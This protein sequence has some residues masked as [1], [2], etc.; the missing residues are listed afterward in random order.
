MS[1]DDLIFK[2]QNIN[3]NINLK[4]VENLGRR[5]SDKVYGAELKVKNDKIIPFYT[6]MDTYIKLQETIMKAK[7]CGYEDE[8]SI[9]KILRKALAMFFEEKLQ[10]NNE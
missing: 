1:N 10:N 7:L 5:A 2:K 4:E 6:N 8:T 9:N 3:N